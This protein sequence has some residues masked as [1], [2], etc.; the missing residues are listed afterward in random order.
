MV[1]SVLSSIP[2]YVLTVLKPPK[3][4]FQE[5]DKARRCFLWAGNE[6]M[7]GG[8]CKINW[9]KV[10]SPVYYGG[11]GVP[12]LENFAR[13]LRLRWLWYEWKAPNKP[14][15]GT[16]TPC[17]ELVKELFA[18]STKVTIGDGRKAHYWES[19]WIGGH[20]LK[21]LA[22]NL[23]RHSKRKNRTVQDALQHGRWINDIRH[24][25]TITLLSEYIKI[26]KVLA[27]E[28]PQLTEGVE[29]SI[30]WRW[31]AN[32]EYSA[33]SAY[34]FQFE[35]ITTSPSATLTW[36]VWAPVKCKIFS[37]LAIQNRVWTADRLQIREGG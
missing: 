22:P 1:N 4:F 16:E 15:I 13:A 19:N 12:N 26:W 27:L 7:H 23:Y 33:K 6:E 25:L 24:N 2:T 14:W 30:T 10:C 3:Q 31:M 35:G 29:D 11:L 18:A 37:W 21:S 36:E 5:I 8:K 28:C 20:R 9:P 34:L 32:G 17:D